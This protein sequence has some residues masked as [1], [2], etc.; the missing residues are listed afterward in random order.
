MRVSARDVPFVRARVFTTTGELKGVLIADD[1]LGYAL[2]QRRDAHG[3]L[4][5]TPNRQ[6]IQTE[7]FWGPVF[8]ERQRP[9]NPRS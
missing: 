4:K 3:R 9:L 1:E 7:E 2:L 5:L 8:I 6:A